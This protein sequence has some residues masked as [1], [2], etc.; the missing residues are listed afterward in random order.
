MISKKAQKL[1]DE[2]NALWKENG[3]KWSKAYEDRLYSL[4]EEEAELLSSSYFESKDAVFHWSNVKS[5]Y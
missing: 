2:L 1:I 4:T 5:C 3:S